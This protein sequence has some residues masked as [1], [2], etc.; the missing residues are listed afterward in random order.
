MVEEELLGRAWVPLGV[1]RCRDRMVRPVLDGRHRRLPVAR[2]QRELPRVGPQQQQEEMALVEEREL[3][4][5]KAPE[6]VLEQQRAIPS[7]AW[8][9]QG[10]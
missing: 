4:E 7:L 9:R 10:S 2:P 5:E 1:G 3:A 8:D 6:M